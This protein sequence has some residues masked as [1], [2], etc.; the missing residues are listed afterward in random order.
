MRIDDIDANG[1]TVSWGPPKD[2][3]GSE[4]T[5]YTVEKTAANATSWTQCGRVDAD[6]NSF[7]VNGLVEGKEY[8]LQVKTI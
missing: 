2:D 8:R 7:R 5:H 3:G 1:C 6:V 4:V